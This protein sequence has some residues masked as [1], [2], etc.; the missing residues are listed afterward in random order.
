M[1]EKERVL[2][3]AYDR[4]T[5]ELEKL[6]ND[7]IKVRDNNKKLIH[8]IESSLNIIHAVDPEI[9]NSRQACEH[10]VK[11]GLKT[12]KEVGHL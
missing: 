4:Q 8:C 12:L 10:I 6:N 5:K 11:D 2:I 7:Y 1:Q 9:M 3:E